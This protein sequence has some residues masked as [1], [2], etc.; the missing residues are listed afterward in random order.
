MIKDKITQVLDNF[1]WTHGKHSVRFGGK[2]RDDIFSQYGNQY[3]RNQ[4]QFNRQYTADPQTLKGGNAAADFSL[5]R[6]IG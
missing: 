2:Y 5:E 1:T 3:T 6:R 4:I